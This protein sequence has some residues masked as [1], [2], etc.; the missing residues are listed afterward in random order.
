MV[1]TNPNRP[2]ASILAELADV[3]AGGVVA[4]TAKRELLGL[5]PSAG[6]WKRL[7]G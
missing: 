7:L 4:A 5:E 6:L 2:A 1:S 3:G